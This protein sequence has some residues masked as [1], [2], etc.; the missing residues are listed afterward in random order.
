MQAR[1]A[2]TD[3][4]VAVRFPVRTLGSF[5]LVIT[6]AMSASAQTVTWS[7]GAGPGSV[8]ERDVSRRGRPVDASPVS[9]EGRGPAFDAEHDRSTPNRTHHFE[10]SIEKAGGFVFKTPLTSTPRSTQDSSMVIGGRYEYRRYALTD[11]VVDGLDLGLGL[12]GGVVIQSLAQHFD[13]SIEVHIRETDFSLAVAAAARFRRWK[14][15]EIQASWLNGGIVGRAT[16]PSS[17]YSAAN[18]CCSR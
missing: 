5:V 18:R 16:Q 3:K 14:A 4:G 11:F 1:R 9:W 8:W 15:L 7:V 13:P 17:R 6:A 12:Q 2:P 10:A